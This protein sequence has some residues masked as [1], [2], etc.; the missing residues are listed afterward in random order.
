[1]N[2][3]LGTLKIAGWLTFVPPLKMAACRQRGIQ[4]SYSGQVPLPE[5][6]GPSRAADE[7]LESLIRDKLFF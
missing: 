1:M 6:D 2:K 7:G 3:C 5:Q 4:S